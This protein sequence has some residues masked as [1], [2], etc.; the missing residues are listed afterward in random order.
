MST[1]GT[2]LMLQGPPCRFWQELAAGLRAD[3]RRVLHI[4]FCL[5]DWASWH[6][7]EQRLYR[8]R[9]ADWPERLAAIVAREAVSDILYYA[10]GLPYHRAA[11]TVARRARVRAWV[12]ENGYL[13]PDW[14]TFEP[15]G[16]GAASHFPRD[17][18]AIRQL[19][20]GR[21]M[22]DLTPKHLHGFPREAASEVLFH[23]AMTLGRPLFPAYVS[24]KYY[25]PVLDYLCWLRKWAFGGRARR[26]ALHTPTQP[27]WLVALQLQ[28]DYQIRL[29]S[30]FNCLSE[31]LGRVIRSF[32][33]HAPRA[34]ELIVK[35]HPMDNGWQRWP[36]RIDRIARNHGVASRVR[37][38]DGGALE[39][40]IAGANGVVTVNSTVGIHTLRQGR[41]VIALGDA[42][43]DVPGLTHQSGLDS[44][45]SSPERPE[46]LL[47]DAFA[48]ALAATIQVR[49]SFYAPEGRRTAVAEI[50]RRLGMAED[51]WQLTCGP[52]ST[53][54]A[55]PGRG[56]LIA[57]E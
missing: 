35:L 1:D 6:G 4:G 8:G 16:M 18:A 23:L 15:E 32:A 53:E 42:V 12:I 38:I 19:A 31:M 57:A 13:R 49:G 10:D 40:L 26:A 2:V 43:Y 47:F 9:L 33:T 36:S 56:R 52:R 21:P 46:S 45:W 17:P 7:P 37:A 22:P 50:V 25:P 44:F 51:V 48:A 54:C 29:S 20:E 11:V 34:G 28:S 39:P 3:G 41:P 27:Y 5:A 14:L 55:E 30:P 24:D